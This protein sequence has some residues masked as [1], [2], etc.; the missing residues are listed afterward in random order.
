MARYEDSYNP[1]NTIKPSGAPSDY[2]N[3]RAN[4]DSFGAQVG[5]SV[6]GLGK[7]LGGAANQLMSYAVQEQGLA[8]E[9][10]ATMAELQ[11][12]KDGGEVYNGYKNLEGLDA[13]NARD[14][15]VADY[16]TLNQ[17]IRS[18]IS[19]DAARRA[20]DQL[21]TRRVA[22]AVQ[23][24]NNYA[25]QQ[26]KSA[27]KA[28]QTAALNQAINDVSSYSVA[29]SPDQFNY[30]MQSAIFA[31][32][33]LFTAPEY[34]DFQSV[35][36]KTGKDGK[37]QFDIT[38][39]QGRVAQ[40]TYD[41]YLDTALDKVYTNAV[42]TLYNDPRQG[43]INKA[44]NFLEANKPNMSA[45]TYAKLSKGLHAPF[46]A[47][48]TR[49]GAQ[50][51]MADV[52]R[53][54][55]TAI[56]GQPTQDLSTSITNLFP[57]AAVTSGLRSPEHN[58]AVGGVDNS[59]HLTGNAIDF[60]APPGTTVEQIRDALTHSGYNPVEIIDE[61]DHFHV[62][63][64]PQEGSN[65]TTFADYVR[66]NGYEDI[67]AKG[68]V[69]AEKTHPGDLVFQGQ[70]RQ[71]LT[72]QLN[73]V[74]RDQSR[75]NTAN[76]NAVLKY[77]NKANVSNISQLHNAPRDVK[78]SFENL[79]VSDPYAFDNFNNII[80]SKSFSK[81][82]G[83]GPAFY[84]NFVKVAQGDVDSITDL[85]KEVRMQDGKNSPLTNT[86][87]ETLSGILQRYQDDD[88][89]LKPDGANFLKAQ[90][91]F[92][93]QERKRRVGSWTSPYDTNKNFNDF[94]AQ[95][96][97]QIE[98]RVA[99]GLKEGKSLQQISHDLFVPKVDGKDNPNFVRTSITPPDPMT[100]IKQRTGT[101]A[102][103]GNTPAKQAYKNVNE[104][105]EAYQGNKISKEEAQK[106]I[107]Q[108]GWKKPEIPSVPKPT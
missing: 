83:Y 24:I 3:V 7:T 73:S 103:G 99:A 30:S 105:I 19:N 95:A 87:F 53:D 86:G 102:F 38:T 69:Y 9:H 68:D 85:G 81:A 90:A 55:S 36:A 96:I 44:V 1:N 59:Y 5:Q 35:P 98:A 10:E 80:T 11:L 75:V 93:D 74:V 58:K 77:L 82:S 26:K 62:A 51:V 37:L 64:K 42:D 43:D 2:L 12:A 28:G 84:Q 52:S 25:S 91:Q 17:K 18:G 23:D 104:L 48:Q 92:L 27:Y 71:Q 70:V 49:E 97:P 108:N 40:H 67:L 34:G 101:F 54:Y 79:L 20:Y 46:R 21:A 14:K 107:K 39:E 6:Q 47:A 57:G 41:N 15:A 16:M 56:S 78:E 50:T 8:N 32:N 4:P 76:R 89:K 66:G 13:A 65:Y 60:V 29:S 61:K 106:L 45:G 63:V 72:Q 22:F 33:T 88:G 94:L 31:A 100:L